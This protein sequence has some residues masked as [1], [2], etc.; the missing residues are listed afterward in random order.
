M[1]WVLFLL[2]I[3]LV[4]SYFEEY[5]W[6]ST[7]VFI[8][9]ENV[10]LCFSVILVNLFR[11][12]IAVLLRWRISVISQIWYITKLD[13]IG[14]FYQ[15][16]ELVTGI[17]FGRGVPTCMINTFMF[18]LLVKAVF[19]EL[20]RWAVAKWILL[21]WGSLHSSVIWSSDL[22]SLKLGVWSGCLLVCWYGLTCN[23]PLYTTSVFSFCPH[24]TIVSALF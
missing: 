5:V 11:C 13:W 23:E 3:I 9:V 24:H 4:H 18:Y 21:L 19:S 14:L 17:I 10:K 16:W 1:I 6:V 15:Y 8:L 2:W 12:V 22:F 7:F 20:I